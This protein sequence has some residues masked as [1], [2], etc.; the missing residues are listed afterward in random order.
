MLL[1]SLIGAGIIAGATLLGG[2]AT[3]AAD[4][5]NCTAAD[6]T[7]VLSGVNAGMS[8]YL[9]THPD[10]NAFFTGLKG[11]SRDEM[12]TEVA[13]YL[14]ANPDIRDQIEAV[15]RPAADFRARCDAPMPDEM[16]PMS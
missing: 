1:R 14:Q 15:R 3:A 2:A 10:V 4:E 16:G 12:R 8:V 9:F 13:N 11:K 6:L 7:Q 5:P